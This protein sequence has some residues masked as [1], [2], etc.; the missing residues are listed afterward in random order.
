MEKNDK[1]T[2]IK[3]DAQ[4]PIIIG[5]GFLSRLQQALLFL[6]DNKSNE[7]LDTLTEHIKNENIPIDTWMYHFETISLIIR[8]IETNAI[9]KGLTEEMDV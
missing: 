7:E 4:I 3:K 8:E 2:L 5:T 6:V 9:K 1:I